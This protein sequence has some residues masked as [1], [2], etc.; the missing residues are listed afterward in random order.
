MIQVGS[1]AFVGPDFTLLLVITFNIFR[2]CDSQHIDRMAVDWLSD[3]FTVVVNHAVSARVEI[4]YDLSIKGLKISK[5]VGEI[6]GKAHFIDSRLNLINK[7]SLNCLVI[8]R[9]PNLNS[10]YVILDNSM[11]FH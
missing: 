6:R 11:V 1:L 10:F 5:I 8:S 7:L 2:R 3:D 4:I 9:L